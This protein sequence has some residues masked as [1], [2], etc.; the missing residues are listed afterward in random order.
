[1]TQEHWAKREVR[2]SDL[3]AAEPLGF[4][5]G[6][7]R[8]PRCKTELHMALMKTASLFYWSSFIT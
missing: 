3:Y 6:G 1:M 5:Q 4:P 7:C 8:V 2:L